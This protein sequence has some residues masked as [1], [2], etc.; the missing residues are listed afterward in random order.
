MFTFIRH[1]INIIMKMKKTVLL[2]S[3]SVLSFI[4]CANESNLATTATPQLAKPEAI[5]KFNAAI[6]Q[7][8][9]LTAQSPVSRTSAELSDDKKDML[10]P[11][12]KE[13]IISSGVSNKEL[14]RQTNNDREK[15]LKWAVQLYGDY[16]KKANQNYQSQN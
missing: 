14:E 9:I 11:A 4:S 13:L 16:S 6:K 10:I 8:A 3:I 1:K 15:I 5:S 12:A 2:L 7:V